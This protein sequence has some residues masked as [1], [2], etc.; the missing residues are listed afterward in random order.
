M[1]DDA[2]R[3]LGAADGFAHALVYLRQHIKT[4]VVPLYSKPIHPR[5]VRKMKDREQRM[6]TLLQMEAYLV[7]QY[8][9]CLDAYHK[10]KLD[11]PTPPRPWFA[12]SHDVYLLAEQFLELH[13]LMEAKESER[14]I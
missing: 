5:H 10:H 12:E 11:H 13:F 1:D 7:E 2:A 9:N 6:A 14:E 3:V 8:Q 4:R